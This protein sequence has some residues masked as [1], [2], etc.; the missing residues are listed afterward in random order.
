MSLFHTRLQIGIS[1]IP[2]S[3]ITSMVAPAAQ[4]ITAIDTAISSG[5][6]SSVT[7]TGVGN[8][9]FPSANSYNLKFDN[10]KMG[11]NGYSVGSQAYRTFQTDSTITIRR[12]T[13]HPS[14]NIVWYQ[15]GPD[16]AGFNY[17]LRGEL[18]GNM[19]SVFEATDLY[20]GSD[21]IFCNTGDA[22]G[23]NNNIERLDI[24]F[25]NG[26]V[27]NANLAFAAFERGGINAHD[28]FTIAAI[29][30]VDASGNPTSYGSL[31]TIATGWGSQDL[32][33]WNTLVERNNSVDGEAN[34]LSAQINGQH[35]GGV[36]I[37]VQQDLGVAAGATFY[38][39]SLFANDV[40]QGDNLVNYS[41]FKTDTSAANGGLDL[42]SYN[43]ILYEVAPIET[44]PE[45]AAPCFLATGVLFAVF[46]RRGPVANRS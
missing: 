22:N 2:L 24:V 14:N 38:G 30:S 17:H 42:T 39:Y 3:L 4:T 34:S 37:S 26:V 1:I 23:N 5:V 27:S 11:L 19:A 46:R 8:G 32:G 10:S 45:P 7:Q 40:T 13:S 28:N 29:T 12:N 43:G 21:N 15:R 35:L 44:V 36:S 9:A 20:R 31:I 33:D 16:E 41:S 18:D 6:A 25:S